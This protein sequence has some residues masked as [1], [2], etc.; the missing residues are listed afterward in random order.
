MRV[1]S[2][3]SSAVT[4]L[5]LT[6]ISGGLGIQ[7][8]EPGWTITVRLYICNVPDRGRMTACRVCQSETLSRKQAGR[9]AL[10]RFKRRKAGSGKTP[11]SVCP[12]GG[13][14]NQE[15]AGGA[16]RGRQCQALQTLQRGF[17]L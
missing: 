16:G 2:Q 14:R 8:I 12:T 11:P 17:S 6:V 3:P 15:V 5:L 4:G 10:I 13:R 7:K 9:T 1:S